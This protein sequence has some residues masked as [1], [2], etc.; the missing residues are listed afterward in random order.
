MRSGGSMCRGSHAVV[1]YIFLARVA[2]GSVDP[3]LFLR[4]CEACHSTKQLFTMR[5]HVFGVCSLSDGLSSSIHHVTPR[6]RLLQIAT[7]STI[8][9][10]PLQEIRIPPIHLNAY[11]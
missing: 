10:T 7:F 8:Q 1:R 9:P 3:C 4:A 6:P 5:H 2:F 11:S